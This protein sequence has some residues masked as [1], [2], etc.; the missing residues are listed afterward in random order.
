MRE[1]QTRELAAVLASVLDPV[2]VNHRSA[3][4]RLSLAWPTA[5]GPAV[6]RHT[7]PLGLRDALLVVG[8]R[9]RHWREAVFQDRM[10]LT[11]RLRRYWK[12]LRGIRLDSLPLRPPVEPTAEPH[13]VEADPRT[14][15]IHDAELRAA[16]DGLLAIRGRRG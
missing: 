16:L 4:R 6:A 1:K 3:F 10:M 7:E 14:A 12:P 11:D 15:E 13:L 2:A 8:V 5:C 9:G